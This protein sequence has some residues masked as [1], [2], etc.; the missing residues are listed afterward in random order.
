MRAC[1]ASAT[2][3]PSSPASSTSGVRANETHQ[4]RILLDSRRNVPYMF[5]YMEHA[6]AATQASPQSLETP[7][8]A[9]AGAS[10]PL[11]SDLVDQILA[12]GRD[13][14][15]GYEQREDGWTP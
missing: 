11:H 5:S 12:S 8:R 13:A 4:R 7:D 3:T 1:S 9:H 15:P 10:G 14:R 6:I 2:S